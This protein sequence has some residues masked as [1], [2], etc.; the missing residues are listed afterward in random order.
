MNP[1]RYVNQLAKL[2]RWPVKGL[3]LLLVLLGI[4]Y[5]RP[6]LLVRELR[7]S[8]DV[9]ALI[10][11]ESP[12][13]QPWIEE[14]REA[15]A[16]HPGLSDQR[17]LKAV[18]LYVYE[19]IP[20]DWDW[21]TWGVLDYIPTVSEVLEMGREDCDGRAVVAA[22][23]IRGLGYEPR[24]VNDFKHMWVW[25]PQGEFMSPTGPKVFEPTETGS[26]FNWKS[27]LDLPASIAFG[28]AVYPLGRE[29][30]MLVAIWL[31]GLKPV[32]R[33]WSW[34]LSLVALVQGLLFMR[35]AAWDAYAII[36]WGVWLGWLNLAVGLTL[37]WL[38][39]GS[40]KAAGTG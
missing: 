3:F 22:S 21:N 25:T 8:A 13:I 27:L 5:P 4:T 28:L 30:V 12:G 34:W 39:P 29:L 11:A 32:T 26:R 33:R 20:Y 9:S 40:R 1:L 14:I 6:S 35:L 19:K 17:V 37:L 31:C 16:E 7:H 38:A 24:L 15:V 2:R 18:E 23:L 36:H 10:D